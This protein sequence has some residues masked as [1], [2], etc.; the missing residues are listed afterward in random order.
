MPVI[1][2][3]QKGVREIAF[4]F[5]DGPNPKTTPK[6]LGILAKHNIKAVFFVLGEKIATPE[7]RQ[8]V[9]RAHREGHLIGNH[10]HS[11]P[12][13]K[14]LSEQQIRSEITRTHDLICE[15]VSGCKIFRPP[16]GAINSMVN[17][18]LRDLDYD[19]VMWNVDTLDWKLKTNGAWVEHGM[20]QIKNREDSLVLMHDIHPT[21]VNNVENLIARIKKLPNTSFT[22][23]Q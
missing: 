6:L 17:K 4:T 18:V 22:L 1:Y 23:Y 11:H 21:T 5:D 14:K 8:I 9:E 10:S 15:C 3:S 20:T 13:L 2:G 19:S 7:G 12:N 16:Y